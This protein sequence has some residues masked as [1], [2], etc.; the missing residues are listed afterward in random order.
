MLWDATAGQFK[1]CNARTQFPDCLVL[2]WNALQHIVVFQKFLP[3]ESPVLHSPENTVQVPLAISTLYSVV[4]NK[5][6]KNQ[7]EKKCDTA[8]SRVILGLF[9]LVSDEYTWSPTHK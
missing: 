5:A 3:T 8:K 2:Q 4:S 1:R 7:G 6:V 9:Q